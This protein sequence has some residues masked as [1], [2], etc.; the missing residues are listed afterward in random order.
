MFGLS[1]EQLRSMAQF[2]SLMEKP[3]G[4]LAPAAGSLS[5]PGSNSAGYPAVTGSASYI[6]PV[7]PGSTTAGY[8]AVTG[9]AGSMGPGGPGSTS[10]GYPV[11]PGTV[12][13][14]TYVCSKTKPSHTEALPLSANCD[15]R[16]DGVF[17]VITPTAPHTGPAS[18]MPDPDPYD[19]EDGDSDQLCSGSQSKTGSTV[20]SIHP[21]VDEHITSEEDE[22]EAGP[23]PPTYAEAIDSLRRRLGP[24][25][26]P[27]LPETKTEKGVSA[28]DFFADKAKT[29]PNT[30]LPQCREVYT[31]LSG[32]NS[33]L[34]G[35]MSIPGR[36]LP[37]YPRALVTGKYPK[38]SPPP[39]F[40]RHSYDAQEPVLSMEPPPID[41]RFRELLRPGQS[42]PSA[43]TLT[44][45][46]LESWER[47]ARAG[48]QVNSHSELFLCGII[49][50]LSKPDPTQD[51]LREVTKYLQVMAQAQAHSLD[52][53]TRL[54]AGPLLAR[55]DAC[56]ARSSLD[57]VDRSALRVQPVEQSTLFG[58]KLPE[59]AQLHKDD[60]TRTSLQRAASGQAIKHKPQKPIQGSTPKVS[61][62]STTK[63]KPPA[64]APIKPPTDQRFVR[65][66]GR[67][68]KRGAFKAQK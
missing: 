42:I 22:V 62:A 15:S 25:V 36:V 29:V 47:L 49:K 34:Q 63:S 45:A 13:A 59:V 30:A 37:Q 14:T 35:Q 1:G 23:S 9:I 16:S 55:R 60:L 28:L 51:D 10:T 64:S 3:G 57:V 17:S 43:H 8:P 52:I 27:P 31:S 18:T 61:M 24:G 4:C 56:L 6:G 41:P 12:T 2:V 67:G 39:V 11:V 19:Q 20:L 50:I 65:G 53:L 32:L 68:G 21:G 40:A 46:T 7:G 38:L 26:C 58:N 5:V 44:F 48:I 33:R 54:A 66:R